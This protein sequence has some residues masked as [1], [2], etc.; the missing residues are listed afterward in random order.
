MGCVRSGVA[1]LHVG[2]L[3][4][5][6]GRTGVFM[7]TMMLSLASAGCDSMARLKTQLHTAP[8]ATA[9]AD[10]VEAGLCGL[11]VIVTP[12]TGMTVLVDGTPLSHTSPACHRSLAPGPHT[13]YV[14][15]MGYYSIA[16]PVNL[17]ADQ[18]LRLP[19]ALRPRPPLPFAGAVA[20]V[21]PNTKPAG[22]A[23]SGRS[24][25]AAPEHNHGRTQGT[26][27]A[28]Q[29]SGTLLPESSAIT[30]HMVAQPAAPIVVDN[31]A[32]DGRSVRLRRARGTLAIGNLVLS[33]AVSPGRLVD[34]L[35][36]SDG[37]QWFRDGA[38][39]KPGSD[40]RLGRGL[41]RLRRVA[42]GGQEQAVVLRRL[43]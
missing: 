26:G 3:P 27:A 34:F 23:P 40:L 1:P 14:R 4:P 8:E 30:L 28:P 39:I 33:Y 6:R 25:P 41:L 16:L 13:V 19:V 5:K 42:P 9:A 22:P 10:P 43:G 2:L 24:A 38:Q 32:T 7:L 31:E 35:V 12:P 15:A 37:C 17:L 18:V 36:P 29:I 20:E 11:D 21:G